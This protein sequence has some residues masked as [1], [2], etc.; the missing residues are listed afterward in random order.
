MK[1]CDN[2]F[3]LN[4]DGEMDLLET[5]FLLDELERMEAESELSDGF[6]EPDEDD[7]FDIDDDDFDDEDDSDEDEDD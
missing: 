7:E 4:G 3:D 5:A 6:E 1:P 2:P